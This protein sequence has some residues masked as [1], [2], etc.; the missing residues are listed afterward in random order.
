M[1]I[2]SI[3]NSYSQDAQ[4]YL[5]RIA[6]ADGVELDTYN[7][8]IGGCPLS[9]HHRNMLS[10][11]AVYGLEINGKPT[12]F[13]VSLKEAL[14]NRD[15]DVITVQQA[16]HFSTKYS[17]YQPY[18]H[19]LVEYIRLCV[20]QAKIYIQQTW[21]YEQDSSRLKDMMGYA[22]QKD[23]F[24]D[25]KQAYA[26]AAEDEKLDGI[27]PSGEVLQALL[28]NGI[29]KVHRDTFHASMGLGRYTLGLIWYKVITGKDIQDNAFCKF[30]EEVTDEQ[31][32]IAKK[33]V[34]EVYARYY[35]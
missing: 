31:I 30:D 16:S 19:N 20:P 14:L 5:S 8:M 21:A 34:N 18:L 12:G 7:L 32:A 27:I 10:E 23:M 22:D 26:Q 3:G 2:L 15:W 29:E 25:L 11:K 24:N 35:K 13:Q 9:R 28:A 17:T 4:R 33:S 1:N 6:E